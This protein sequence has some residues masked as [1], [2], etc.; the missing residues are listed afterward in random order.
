MK[1]VKLIY[2]LCLIT[3]C[4]IL[5]A[6]A[7]VVNYYSAING[8]NSTNS[9]PQGGF[10]ESLAFDSSM[11]VNI[12]G[13]TTFSVIYRDGEC[14]QST[15]YNWKRY[16][17]VPEI[18]KDSTNI[19]NIN[20]NSSNDRFLV[21]IK[22]GISH[23]AYKIDEPTGWVSSCN[24]GGPHTSGI[25]NTNTT[26]VFQSSLT[27][28]AGITVT[29]KPYSFHVPV[30]IV[31]VVD[32][33]GNGWYNEV[34]SYSPLAMANLT[35]NIT[36]FC[37]TNQSKYD[38]DF[39]SLTEGVVNEPGFSKKSD[40]KDLYINCIEPANITLSV[41]TADSENG[42]P[43]KIK[44]GEDLVSDFFIDNVLQNNVIFT[45]TKNIHVPLHAKL[46]RNI[47]S[48]NTIQAGLYT[49]A[50]VVKINFQ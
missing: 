1:I 36:N 8:F 14:K 26:V 40:I 43:N 29:A 42:N 11:S 34:L 9:F 10:I 24:V 39:G 21:G 32:G 7:G 4:L 6:Q 12:S 27:K 2:G 13:K 22:D 28:E 35:I 15:E 41:I 48:T 49:G 50:T 19:L 5:K 44:M 3:S 47:N 16:L 30:R 38:F 37:N 46:R 20:L 31:A 25:A 18:V 45:D 23:Y 17:I 33:T